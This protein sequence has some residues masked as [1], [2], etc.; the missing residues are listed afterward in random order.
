M[1]FDGGSVTVVFLETI[2]VHQVKACTIYEETEELLEDGSDRQS[3][4]ALAHRAEQTIQ[5]WGEIDPSQVTHEQ[6]QSC[7][8]GEGI[9]GDL[10]VVDGGL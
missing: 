6:T 5:M 7:P 4:P 8:T 3:L 2:E 10:N 9:V 1:G